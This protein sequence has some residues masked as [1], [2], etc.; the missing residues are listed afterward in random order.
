MN[1]LDKFHAWILENKLKPGHFISWVDR[2]MFKL[3]YTGRPFVYLSYWR[4]SVFLAVYWF[5][6]YTLVAYAVCLVLLQ[7]SILPIIRETL[8]GLGLISLF[9]GFT[10]AFFLKKQARKHHLPPWETFSCTK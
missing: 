3:G 2:L 10:T 4:L 5:F 9:F 7:V 8:W 1:P 6:T